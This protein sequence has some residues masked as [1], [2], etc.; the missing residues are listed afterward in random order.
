MRTGCVAER[1][2]HGGRQTAMLTA[3]SEPTLYAGGIGHEPGWSR[4]R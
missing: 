1:L 4:A 3:S 2:L